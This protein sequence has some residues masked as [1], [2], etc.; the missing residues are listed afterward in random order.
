MVNKGTGV[1]TMN[2]AFSSPRNAALT[3]R[4]MLQYLT[5]SL[6]LH[7]CTFSEIKTHIIT[8]SDVLACLSLHCAGPKQD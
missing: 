6:K 8:L 7:D 2:I 1:A 4:K 5:F 3:E